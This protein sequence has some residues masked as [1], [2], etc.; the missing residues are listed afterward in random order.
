M[1][2]SN[3]DEYIDPVDTTYITTQDEYGRPEYICEEC[4]GIILF[5][6]VLADLFQDE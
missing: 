3:C 5:R 4:E 6:D 1:K 2:C